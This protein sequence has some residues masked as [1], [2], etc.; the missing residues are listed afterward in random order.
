MTL[1]P[2]IWNALPEK[3]KK[4]TSFRKFKEYFK[5]WSGPIASAKCAQVFRNYVNSLVIREVYIH[6]RKKKKQ[7]SSK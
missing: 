4:E 3:I 5:S 6:L 2:K 7:Q 1:G